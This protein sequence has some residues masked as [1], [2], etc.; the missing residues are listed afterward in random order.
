MNVANILAV[1]DAIEAESVCQ[2][3]MD[4]W[5]YTDPQCGTVGCIA[6]TAFLMAGHKFGIDHPD[7]V[8]AAKTKTLIEVARDFLGISE[9]VARE[10]FMPGLDLLFVVNKRWAARTLRNLAITGKVDWLGS[11][12]ENNPPLPEAPEHEIVKSGLKESV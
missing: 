3:R 8:L 4:K 6:G 7:G 11:A 10:L 1:A 2:F 9:P 5:G 12:A